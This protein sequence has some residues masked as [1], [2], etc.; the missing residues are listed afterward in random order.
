[1]LLSIQA[2]HVLASWQ[3]LDDRSAATF[4]F[5]S[6]RSGLVAFFTPSNLLQ[7]YSEGGKPEKVVFLAQHPISSS[8]IVDKNIAWISVQGEGV[9]KGTQSW[10]SWTKVLES[11]NV[12]VLAAT[13]K[14][15]YVNDRG[16]LKVSFDDT[17]YN[18][19]AGIRSGDSI[20][21]I[22]FMTEDELVAV[23]ENYAYRS[24]NGGI[25][26]VQ[27][28]VTLLHSSSI[29]VD[30]STGFYYV[31]DVD[32]QRQ[33]EGGA[34][35]VRRSTNGGKSWEPMTSSYFQIA[36]QVAGAHDC[37]GVFYI[38][39]SRARIDLLRSQTRGLFFQ[40]VG[41]APISSIKPNKVAV[42]NRGAVIYWL[43][44][45]GI[46]SLS[47]NGANETIEDSLKNLVLAETD[48]TLQASY[49]ADKAI[50]VPLHLKYADCIE[51]RIDSLQILT[52][53]TGFTSQIKNVILNKSTLDTTLSFKPKKE[54]LDSVRVKLWFHSSVTNYR[55]FKEFNAKVIVTAEDPVLALSTE[56][57]EFGSV[58]IDSTKKLTFTIEN[59]GCDTL[60]ITSLGSS[61]P[62]IFFTNQTKFPIK[63][64]SGKKVEITVTF[65]PEQ[66]G[67]ILESL[68][69]QTNVGVRFLPLRGK[70]TPLP[71]SSVTQSSN[72]FSFYPNPASS[73][74]QITPSEKNNI[75]TLHLFNTLGKEVLSEEI[76]TTTTITINHLP[77]GVYFA[78]YG[79]ELRRV[80]IA[81]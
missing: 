71:Q 59:T 26:W 16:R 1:V 55:E 42:Y 76:R 40:N 5:L 72:S 33:F 36:G 22:D 32:P 77:T 31:G 12:Y 4:D 45:S 54:G 37:S 19:A 47:Y 81:R 56:K 63:I 43:D 64:P 38:L 69:L 24:I 11:P 79:N 61:A 68:D 2:S 39:P 17:T 70:V 44:Q 62:N 66:E 46:L 6:D 28:P 74:L 80:V 14:A 13:H 10:T 8:V 7:K 67:D 75:H 15:V 57:I 35:T 30:R 65:D 50:S 23:S 51:L 9:Y 73:F 34:D 52:P 21:A 53:G 25:S 29:Y 48:T 3:Q 41:P 58:R 78:H 27:L 18:N 49:C 60:M 20:R